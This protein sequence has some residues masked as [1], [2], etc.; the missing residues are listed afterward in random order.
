MRNWMFFGKMMPLSQMMLTSASS[1]D[2]PKSKDPEAWDAEK[3][4]LS[5][6]FKCG[7]DVTHPD[8][9]QIYSQEVE[10][11]NT[12]RTHQVAAATNNSIGVAGD[13]SLNVN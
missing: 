12:G 5:Q 1:T 9:A 3:E 11:L 7:A 8:L 13:V 2:S 4:C 10:T 6:I